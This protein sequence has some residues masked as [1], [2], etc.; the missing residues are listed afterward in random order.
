MEKALS[1]SLENTP[2]THT[3]YE[4]MSKNQESDEPTQPINLTDQPDKPINPQSLSATPMSD[5]NQQGEIAKQEKFNK[6]RSFEETQP[7]LVK[8]EQT[9]TTNQQGPPQGPPSDIPDWLLRFAAAESET[10]PLIQVDS[11]Q[12]PEFSCDNLNIEETTEPGSKALNPADTQLGS[13][14]AEWIYETETTLTGKN[15][16]SIDLIEELDRLSDDVEKSAAAGESSG[17]ELEKHTQQEIGRPVPED[18]P[19][20][21]KIASPPK[22]TLA[23]GSNLE[24][25]N[26]AGVESPKSIMVDSEKWVQKF[27][28][29]ELAKGEFAGAANQIRERA[30]TLEKKNAAQ[31]AIRPYLTLDPSRLPLWEINA[32]LL[33]EL[34]QSGLAGESLQACNLIKINHGGISGT[35]TGIS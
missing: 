25:P 10:L 31:T 3:N 33:H 20:R 27:L 13:A 34:G 16:E 22:E 30:D 19:I 17:S 12:N 35:I 6:V 14:A 23:S 15:S 1:D 21:E 2:Q 28:E 7:I 32:E 11:D 9:S 8:P 5:A 4:R 24:N 29:A 26:C 18:L